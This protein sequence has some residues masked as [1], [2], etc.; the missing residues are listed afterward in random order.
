MDVIDY[1]M[2]IYDSELTS[3]PLPFIKNGAG[4]GEATLGIDGTVALENVSDSCHDGIDG[5]GG[6]WG[7]GGAGVAVLGVRLNNKVLRDLRSCCSSPNDC[8]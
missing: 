8:V 2:Y 1:V 7:K 5:R 4:G 3:F 6:K